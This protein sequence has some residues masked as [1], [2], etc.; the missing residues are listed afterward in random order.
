LLLQ[1][2]RFVMK[3]IGFIFLLGVLLIGCDKGEKF[4]NNPPETQLAFES[5]NLTGENRLNSQVR[6]SWF[7]TDVDGYVKGYEISLNNQDWKYVTTQDSTFVFPLEQGKDTTDIDFYVRSIDDLDQKDETPAYLR[8]PL[9]NTAPEVNFIAST[10]PIDSNHL[11]VTFSWL[12]KDLD[13]D[14]SI[15]NAY[16]KANNGDWLEIPLNANVISLTPENPSA[17]GVTNAKIYHNGKFD[18][19]TLS[20]FNINGANTLYLKVVD[21]A[22]AE[23]EPDT[24]NSFYVS[25]KKENMLFISGQ[26]E[27]T[28]NKYKA[29]LSN[30][31]YDFLDYSLA[32]KQ[33]KFWDQTFSLIINNY[34]GLFI[35]SDANVFTNPYN[36]RSALLLEFMAPSL[37]KYFNNNGK[38]FVTTSFTSTSDI[39]SLSEVFPIDSISTSKGQ[40]RLDQDSGIVAINQPTWPNVNPSFLIAGVS[41][42]HPTQDAVP[43]YKGQLK[44]GGGWVGPNVVGAK[45][46]LGGQTS[47]IFFSVQLHQFD[48]DQTA[49]QQLL[50]NMLN[51]LGL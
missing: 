6:L 35:N 28:T 42:F 12:A 34:E 51:E 33:P 14:A 37:Q 1:E 25:G 46:N 36:Q 5:I 31:N 13:G 18:P 24:S 27:A 48:K 20:G 41:P 23:S 7:G 11:V 4:E 2:W 22:G 40:A 21:F 43:L 16:L 19:S 39:T 44:I 49:Q 32:D 30:S 10:L 45:R 8:I 3:K 17:N 50:E 29:L 15:T 38:A 9:K 26:D 47:Q